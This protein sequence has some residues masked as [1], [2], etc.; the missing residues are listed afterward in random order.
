MPQIAIKTTKANSYLKIANTWTRLKLSL[1][2]FLSSAS[3]A[4]ID[5][6]VLNVDVIHLNVGI[7]IFAI[8]I[9]PSSHLVLSAN[10]KDYFM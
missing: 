2:Q 3:K 4:L 9:L 5:E 8:S 1:W 7:I 10:L 6:R